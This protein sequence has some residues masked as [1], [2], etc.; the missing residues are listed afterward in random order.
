MIRDTLSE[1]YLPKILNVSLRNRH[2][3][4]LDIYGRIW[5]WGE[6]AGGRLGDGTIQNRNQPVRITSSGYNDNF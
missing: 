1:G 4:A 5:S 6:N 2:I 3:L